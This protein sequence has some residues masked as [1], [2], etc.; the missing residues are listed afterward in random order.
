MKY[1]ARLLGI[2]EVGIADALTQSTGKERINMS[3]ALV[4]NNIYLDL[5]IDDDGFGFAT[6]I[7][8]NLINLCHC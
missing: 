8:K 2:T 7:R 4:K 6:L 3:N 5:S 1:Q